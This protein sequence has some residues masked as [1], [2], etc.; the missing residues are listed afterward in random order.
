MEGYAE[1]QVAW[2]NV[3]NR[4]GENAAG[5]GAPRGV[6]EIPEHRKQRL[7]P[8]AKPRAKT[9]ESVIDS[10]DDPAQLHRIGELVEKRLYGTAPDPSEL[11]VETE[12]EYKDDG[13]V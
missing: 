11:D 7:Q 8:A 2:E 12:P 4:A 13:W 1:Q 6:R 5:T 3:L 9:W 10:I